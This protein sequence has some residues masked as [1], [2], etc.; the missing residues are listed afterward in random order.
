MI[1]GLARSQPI[2]GMELHVVGD[3]HLRSQ[4]EQ[5]AQS[6]GSAWRC[7]FTAR[8]PITAFRGFI[9]AAD[10]CL[11]P[12]QPSR[13]Y[14]GK[15][16]FSTLKIPEYMACERPV[17]SVPHGHILQLIDHQVTGFLVNNNA[18]AWTA[19]F[20]SMPSRQRACRNGRTAAQ[21]VASLSWNATAARYL[22]LGYRA[23]SA[24]LPVVLL[25]CHH[26]AIDV[27]LLRNRQHG[28]R[29]PV[30]HQAGGKPREHESA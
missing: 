15:I 9:A 13:F 23:A 7:T 6:T 29:D 8:S 16:T 26:Y 24:A 11:A 27:P 19:L 10:L 18:D 14:D 4:D 1:E 12:Y 3:G 22:E 2:D 20:R 30:E 21:R 5:T 17:A 25:L 28:V